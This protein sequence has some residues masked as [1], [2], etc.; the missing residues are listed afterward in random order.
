MGDDD[1]EFSGEVAKEGFN[2]LGRCHGA[3]ACEGVGL[4]RGRVGEELT[5][6][7]KEHHCGGITC[8]TSLF[9]T[10]HTD[11]PFLV[12]RWMHPHTSSQNG[13]SVLC[14]CCAGVLVL[15]LEKNVDS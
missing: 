4:R 13:V 15:F 2:L 6:Y 10:A 8:C 12:V 14:R 3:D 11:I 1:G 7:V 9:L 5:T